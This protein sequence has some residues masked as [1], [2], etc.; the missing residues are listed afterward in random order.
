MGGGGSCPGATHYCTMTSTQ[1]QPAGAP[2]GGQFAATGHTEAV[3]V[4][5][6]SDL[7][8]VEIDEAAA[9]RHPFQQETIAGLEA[10]VARDGSIANW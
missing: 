10:F 7:L 5:L 3:E 1:R 6:D 8:D 9:A 2:T 4:R